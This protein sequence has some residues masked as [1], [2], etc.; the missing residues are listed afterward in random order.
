MFN[1]MD[2]AHITASIVSFFHDVDEEGS[3]GA[4]DLVGPQGSPEPD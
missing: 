1:F 2:G 4:P 3:Q